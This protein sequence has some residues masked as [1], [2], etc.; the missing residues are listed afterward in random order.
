MVLL[1]I[2]VVVVRVVVELRD[3]VD[4]IMIVRVLIFM[5]FFF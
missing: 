4:R 5:L 3:R 1:L 2:V